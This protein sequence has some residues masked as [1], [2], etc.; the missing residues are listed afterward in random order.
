MKV[1]GDDQEIDKRKKE[2]LCFKELRL[3]QIAASRT[4]SQQQSIM[5]GAQAAQL[6]C[7]AALPTWAVIET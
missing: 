3:I 2:Q 5:D 1:N 6:H 4:P 7:P